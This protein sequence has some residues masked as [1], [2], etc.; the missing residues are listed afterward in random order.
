MKEAFNQVTILIIIISLIFG[1]II[2]KV[3]DNVSKKR[4]ERDNEEYG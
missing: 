1:F 3:S 2:Q 4:S